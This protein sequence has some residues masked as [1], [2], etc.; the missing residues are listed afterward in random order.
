MGHSLGMEHD[1]KWIKVSADKKTKRCQ[2]ISK[3]RELNEDNGKYIRCDKCD[4]Y[5]TFSHTKL[6]KNQDITN[7]K[8]PTGQSKD[9]CTGF[10]DYGTPPPIWSECSV[11][12]FE[13]MYIARD[14]NQ[15]MNRG[16]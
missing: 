5:M 3:V 13:D 7:C 14:W 2:T 4:N 12:D 9:C 1:F 10:M 15:C 6:T 11:R 8:K 16:N